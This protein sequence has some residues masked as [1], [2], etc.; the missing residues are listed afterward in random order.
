M[1]PREQATINARRRA[2]YRSLLKQGMEPMK[3]RRVAK[4]VHSGAP[5]QRRQAPIDPASSGLWIP[6]RLRDELRAQLSPV[7]RLAHRLAKIM[8]VTSEAARKMAENAFRG[9]DVKQQEKAVPA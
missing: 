8:G 5:Q 4:A 3:A 6:P 1:S 9:V 7:D 2:L